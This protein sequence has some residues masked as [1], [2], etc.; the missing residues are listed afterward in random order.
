MKQ[1]TITFFGN[2]GTQNL[3]NEC[4][5]KA[6]IQNVRRYL[7]DTNLNCI[8]P[9]P[10][11]TSKRYSIPASLM[12]YRFAGAFTSR[13]PSRHNNSPV[14]R[15]IRRLVIRIPL[16]L[17]E[18]LKAFRRLRRTN[19]LIMTGTGMLSD[20]GTGGPF[21]LHYEILKWSVIARVR[22][23][24]L[25]FVSV[26]AGPLDRPLSRWI[27]KAA[28]SLA[29]YR[30]YRDGFSQQY[31]DS[32]GFNTSKD[33]IYPDL[34]FS[35]PTSEIPVSES[36]DGAGRVIALGLMEH[37]GKCCSPEHGERAYRDYTGHVSRFAAWL[38]KRNYSVRL[39]VG[40]LAYDKRVK[41]DVLRILEEDGLILDP[42]QIIDAPVASVEQLWTQL[43][44]TDM[45]VASR[46][47]NILFALMLNKPV[48]ALSYHQ[49]VNSLMAGVGLAQYCQDI[50]DLNFQ[51][52]VEQFTR[53]EENSESVKCSIKRK[54]DEYRRALDEQYRDI[55][56]EL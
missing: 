10:E 31:L 4:T 23:C 13:A 39:L 37:Y 7:P 1:P 3:G 29:D 51:R 49:K 53:L 41:G 35:L 42:G 48:V 14:I 25:L 19:M 52:L 40:D 17:L 22:R 34:V 18:Y 15:L 33:L 16:E 26:G 30:S 21:G 36:R 55:F 45:V 56:K 6:I 20:F 38:L 43:A 47:H 54:T 12:S 24:R 27:V 5:L 11:D 44:Q 9:N 46:F 50:A 32:I 2:F 28:I 8:C